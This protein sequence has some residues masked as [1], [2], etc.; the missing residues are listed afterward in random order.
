[1]YL[2]TKGLVIEQQ[3][4]HKLRDRQLGPFKVIRKI[5]NRSYGIALPKGHKLH[6]VFHIDKLR[7][8]HSPKPLRQRLNV[9]DELTENAADDT[10]EFEISVGISDVKMN[11]FI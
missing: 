11:N 7:P 10:N 5:G 1:M 4:N 8:A 3:R 2:I 9:T 6:N